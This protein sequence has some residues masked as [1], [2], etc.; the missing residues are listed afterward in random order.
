MSTKASI[1]HHYDE[2]A[3]V[4]IHVYEDVLGDFPQNLRLEVRT[5]HA[6]ID[7]PWPVGLTEE[8]TRK[9]SIVPQSTALQEQS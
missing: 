5:E 2:E 7:V 6:V 3:R 9:L 4:Q 1:L 8:E